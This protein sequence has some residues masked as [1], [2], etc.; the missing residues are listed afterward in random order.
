MAKRKNAETPVAT[1]ATGSTETATQTPAAVT[2]T[3]ESAPEAGAGEAIQEQNPAG[4]QLPPVAT[5]QTLTADDG[6]TRETVI[7]EE[8]EAEVEAVED[9]AN[10]WVAEKIGPYLEAYPFETLFHIASDGNVFLGADVAI[11]REH[12]RTL[13]DGDLYTFR[14]QH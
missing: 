3:T 9:H 5:V 12:Q 11:A 4:E 1:E 8:G 10:E 13:K 14:V 2:G 6:T 7:A